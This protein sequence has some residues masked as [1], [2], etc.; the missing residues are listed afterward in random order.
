MF[1]ALSQVNACKRIHCLFVGRAEWDRLAVYGS[2]G[3]ELWIVPKN[4]RPARLR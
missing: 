1:E 2:C 4:A 3:T